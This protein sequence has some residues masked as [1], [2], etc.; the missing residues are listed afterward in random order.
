MMTLTPE[1]ER[2]IKTI[3][4]RKQKPVEAVLDELIPDVPKAHR[5][6]SEPMPRPKSRSN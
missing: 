2:K 5:N 4:Q 3:A 6:R 1:Q